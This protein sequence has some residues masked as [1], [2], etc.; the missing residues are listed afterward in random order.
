MK[1]VSFSAKGQVQVVIPKDIRSALDLMP[2][3]RLEV[4]V[5]QGKIILKPL[6]ERVGDRL[7]G[8][9]KGSGLVSALEEEHL[10]EEAN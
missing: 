8:R 2:G 6:K 5:R 1:F 7:F 9:L 4:T 10:K 3:D